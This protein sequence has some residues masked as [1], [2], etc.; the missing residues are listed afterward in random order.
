MLPQPLWNASCNMAKCFFL[1]L[2]K[3]C[4]AHHDMR[5]DFDL[6][7]ID[8]IA[9]KVLELLKPY[10][11]Q[12]PQPDMD[13]LLTVEQAARLLGKSRGQIYQWVNNAQHGL[14]DF[15]YGKAGRSLRFSKRELMAWINKHGKPLETG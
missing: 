3:K 15:P 1:Y 9:E 14:G 2:L 11:A 8:C 5:V 10:L 12:I 13:E 4:G 6:R 7:D